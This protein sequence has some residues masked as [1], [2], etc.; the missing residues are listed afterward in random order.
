MTEA[1]WC[2]WT[3]PSE[4]GLTCWHPI[5]VWSHQHP[6][7]R[8]TGGDHVLQ[9]VAFLLKLW[10]HDTT[11]T[12]INQ[13]CYNKQK[14]CMSIWMSSGYAFKG[15]PTQRFQGGT[16][17]LQGVWESFCR[18][19]GALLPCICF[20]TLLWLN[21]VATPTSLVLAVVLK[22]CSTST[23]DSLWWR[24]LL[25]MLLKSC[26]GPCSGLL[27]SHGLWLILLSVLKSFLWVRSLPLCLWKS[28]QYFLDHLSNGLARWPCDLKVIQWSWFWI[29][30]ELDVKVFPN[31]AYAFGVSEFSR[32]GISDGTMK[33]SII[34]TPLQETFYTKNCSS[35]GRVPFALEWAVKSTSYTNKPGTMISNIN[36]I[37]GGIVLPSVICLHAQF[38]T[39]FQISFPILGKTAF[40]SCLLLTIHL[41]WN[42]F[43][44]SFSSFVS[45]YMKL[46]V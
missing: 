18:V 2:H 38:W 14:H 35:S 43:K 36:F 44:H 42:W 23:V 1:V 40:F 32:V 29:N 30:V 25:I 33:A 22:F 34:S 45:K 27:R 9:T 8:P 37:K 12:T 5:V 11:T 20:E 15:S 31:C 4:A 13:L 21:S 28:S 3:G 24:Y 39:P 46:V 7:M 16:R 10:D 17:E 41:V 26:S 19:S 6:S